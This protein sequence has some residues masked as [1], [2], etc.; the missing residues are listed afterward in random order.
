MVLNKFLKK[1]LGLHLLDPSAPSTDPALKQ[2]AR[3]HKMQHKIITN[4]LPDLPL[5][6][7]TTGPNLGSLQE[8]L[9]NMQNPPPTALDRLDQ[10]QFR[11][12]EVLQNE[13]NAQLSQLALLNAALQRA[14]IDSHDLTNMPN[15]TLVKYDVFNRSAAQSYNYWTAQIKKDQGAA[16]SAASFSAQL[17][18]EGCSVSE[19]SANTQK[20]E[21]A[22]NTARQVYNASV[23]LRERWHCGAEP[24]PNV[25]NL[26][27]QIKTLNEK[28]MNMSNQVIAQTRALNKENQNVDMLMHTQQRKLHNHLGR[29][30]DHK[31][32]RNRLSQQQQTLMAEMTDTR[33]ELDSKYYQYIVWLISAV[34]LGSLVF[35]NM[36]KNQ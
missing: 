3:F 12:F 24:C 21:D 32:R 1:V 34:T 2:G 35:H 25:A 17:E 16:A 19:A 26:R 18:G 27:A 14:E 28:I 30:R 31:G 4:V 20:E 13:F 8:S 9:D 15:N 36:M 5:M 10:K 22:V 23:A 33:L 6:D 29:L 11:K 7:Q